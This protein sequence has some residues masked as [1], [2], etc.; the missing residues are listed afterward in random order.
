MKNLY[1]V[2]TCRHGAHGAT[3]CSIFNHVA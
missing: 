2:A 3:W 1:Y